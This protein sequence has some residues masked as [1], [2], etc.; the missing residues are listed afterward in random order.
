MQLVKLGIEKLILVSLTEN[1]LYQIMKRLP[2]DRLVTFVP[3][4]GS[5]TDQR[6]ME[7]VLEDCHLVIHAAAH[8]HVPLCEQNP[9]AAIDNNVFGTYA[10]ARA[11]ANAG[12]KRFVL[13]S[14]DKAVE[15][16]SVMGATK[17]AAELVVR[18]ILTDQLTNYLTVRFGNVRDSAGSVLPLWREQ[19]AAGGPLTLTDPDCK[20][21]FMSIPQAVAL[22][23][24]VATCEYKTDPHIFDMGAPQRMGDIADG[25]MREMGKRVDVVAT[26]LRPGEKLV[27]S[28][29]HGGTPIRTS[30]P[31][32]FRVKEDDTKPLTAATFL[33]LRDYVADR[34]TQAALRTLWE[35]CERMD[36]V[37][38]IARAMKHGAEA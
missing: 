33:R 34:T 18:D 11:A 3:V 21:Y 23:L 20:R 6:L 22:I 10:V 8:K 31:R 36:R 1:G 4:L 5:V 27:E 32:I 37:E 35:I 2:H 14:S 28:L 12:V 29:H 19:I 16:A 24:H 13:V 17:R 30:H 15:P 9:L 25:L 7:D 38:A 26:G